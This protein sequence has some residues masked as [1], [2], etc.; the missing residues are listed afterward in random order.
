MEREDPTAIVPSGLEQ[1][2]GPEPQWEAA[3]RSSCEQPKVSRFLERLK[4][5]RV[6]KEISCQVDEEAITPATA[7]PVTAR[8]AVCPPAAARGTEVS[9]ALLTFYR[10]R[11]RKQ[12]PLLVDP[13]RSAMEPYSRRWMQRLK[14]A[15]SHRE[16]SAEGAQRHPMDSRANKSLQVIRPP[17][18]KP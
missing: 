4:A 7:R 5:K 14:S 12:Q 13:S 9:E 3:V 2:P 6:T 1:G 17:T 18:V 11:S 16:S 10:V 8:Q 15:S